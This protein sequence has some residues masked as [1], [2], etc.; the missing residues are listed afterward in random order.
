YPRVGSGPWDIMDR[1][2]FNGPGG[3]HKRWVVP[4]T[5]GASMPAGLMLRSKMRFEFLK[6]ETLLTVRRSELFGQGIAIGKVAARAIDPPE[7]QL[8]GIV[9]RLDGP[10]PG[11]HTPPED[12]AKNPNS[13]G[14][15]QYDFYSIEVVQRVGYDSF[16]PDN[17]VLVSKNLDQERRGG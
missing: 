13:A 11:D 9:V 10:A 2:S 14:D 8:A 6:P 7:G 16:T 1:G 17:G 15:T 5:D 3:P 12:Y 4:A